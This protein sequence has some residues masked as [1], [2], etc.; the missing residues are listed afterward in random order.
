MTAIAAPA[1]RIWKG[2]SVPVIGSVVDADEYA[3]REVYQAY[4]GQLAGWAARLVGDRDL[5]HD[6]ATEAF[7]RLLNHW[8]EVAEPRPWLYTAAANI[9][10]DHWRK[11]GREQIAYGKVAHQLEVAQDPDLARDL[12]VRSAVQQLPDRLRVAVMLHY[13]ADLPVA[14]VAA[15]MG[16]SE[17]AIKRDL[18]DA[19]K[20]LATILEGAR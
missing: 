4:Y 6:V 8:G 10:R 16:K 9:I 11:R 20:R 15:Q 12:S 13:F 14:Q 2:A 7:V 5:A 3:V 19:R 18:W 17:G 1:P